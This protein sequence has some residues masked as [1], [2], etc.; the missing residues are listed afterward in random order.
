V[1][2]PI[3]LDPGKPTKISATLDDSYKK[4]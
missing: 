1:P 2:A 3:Q 4:P